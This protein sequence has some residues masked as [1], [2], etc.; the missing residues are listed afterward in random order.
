MNGGSTA[1]ST[2]S[3]YLS[4]SEKAIFCTSAIASKWLRFIFQLP[5]IS[6]LRLIVPF[7]AFRVVQ[8]FDAGQRLALKVFQRSPATGGNVREAVLGQAELPH[9]GRRIAAADDAERALAGRADDGLG[10]ALG[11]AANAGNSNTPIGPF[12]KMVLALDSRLVNRFTEPGPMSRPILPSGIGRRARRSGGESAA[13][14]V[15]DHDVDRQMD[16]VTVV[17]E[18]L[19]AGVDH[20]LFEQRGADRNTL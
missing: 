8:H 3:K 16:H 12:Q 1:T 11:A 5:A 20:A 7:R 17:L 14:F 19:A 2:L 13:N 10:D 15:G 9:R 18:Q 4:G 6:G